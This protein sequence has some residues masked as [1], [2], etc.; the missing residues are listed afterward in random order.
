[1]SPIAT[2]AFGVV[3]GSAKQDEQQADEPK[4]RRRTK[5]ELIADAVVPTNDD[6]VSLKD[7]STGQKYE[8]TWLVAVEMFRDGKAEFVDKGLKYAVKKMDQEKGR[9]EEAGA[10]DVE[11]IAQRES[12]ESK[13]SQDE[14]DG[15]EG[16][17]VKLQEDLDETSQRDV[18]KI[19]ALSDEAEQVR[20]KLVEAGYQDVQSDEAYER[21]NEGVGDSIPFVG[22]P[23][24]K[25]DPNVPPDS[26][27]GDEVVIGSD[28]FRVGHGGVLT[29]GSVGL[30]DG[31]IIHPKLRW[32]RELG[33][34]KN[35]PWEFTTLQQPT[36]KP[37]ETK[38]RSVAANTATSPS[39]GGA[40]DAAVAAS[41]AEGA[42]E[43]TPISDVQK[44]SGLVWRVSAGYLEKIGLPEYSSLQIGP[45]VASREIVV[46]DP[47]NVIEVMR[48]DGSKISAPV[49]AVQG[50]RELFHAS[51]IAMRFER[52]AMLSFLEAARGS[53]QG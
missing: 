14:A 49:E 7:L 25:A 47:T 29:S 46:T 5:A 41:D 18:E 23:E 31:T 51:E 48:E 27:V 10:Q 17:W 9:V 35:G 1:M 52:G 42:S 32:Q 16:R 21:R 43:I 4:K 34:G 39:V 13:L 38:A 44:L 45:V 36:T 30:A 15:L 28:V 2:G 19:K 6:Q 8:R 12:L 22:E 40:H 33:S 53:K 50:F 11:T 20:K 26:A 24:R 3:E 37:V